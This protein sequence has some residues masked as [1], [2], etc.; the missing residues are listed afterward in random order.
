MSDQIRILDPH[1][2]TVIEQQCGYFAL[3]FNFK[4]EIRVFVAG[5][6]Y[7]HDTTAWQRFFYQQE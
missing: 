3:T 6:G 4:D 1:V 7:K 2:L 5:T